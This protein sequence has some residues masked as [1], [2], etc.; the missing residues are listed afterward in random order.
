MI[1]KFVLYLLKIHI[2]VF[3]LE[4]LIYVLNFLFVYIKKKFKKKENDLW[5]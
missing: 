2:R 1:L 5:Y 4:K 3:K